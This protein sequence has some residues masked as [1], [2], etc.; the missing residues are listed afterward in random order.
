MVPRLVVAA[1][2][3]NSSFWLCTIAVDISNIAGN[4]VSGLMES[5]REVAVSTDPEEK[6][7]SLWLEKTAMVLSGGA[8]IGGIGAAGLSLS[9]LA[10]LIPILFSALSAILLVILI[11]V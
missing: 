4:T 11:L 8:I 10:L 5:A 2:L 9:S 1:I 6:G 3:V 7:E